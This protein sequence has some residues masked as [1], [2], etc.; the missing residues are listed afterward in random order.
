MGVPLILYV[1]D[2]LSLD[3]P[4]DSKVV[5]FVGKNFINLPQSFYVK[6]PIL[7]EDIKQVVVRDNDC[8]IWR[9]S[10]LGE[11]SVAEAYKSLRDVHVVYSWGKTLW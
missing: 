11:V 6:F 1:D 4:L 10:L 7:V 2:V 8:L 3:P 5:G 9:A